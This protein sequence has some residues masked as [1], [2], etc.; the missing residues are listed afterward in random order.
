MLA[1]HLVIMENCNC[2]G[3]VALSYEPELDPV[4]ME[5]SG[6]VSIYISVYIVVLMPMQSPSFDPVGAILD[7][8]LEVRSRSRILGAMWYN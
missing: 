4:E 7:Y 3:S 5:F 1:V 8:I 6:F 2:H